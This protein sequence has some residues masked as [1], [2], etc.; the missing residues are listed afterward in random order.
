MKAKHQ[1][2]FVSELVVA[3]SYAKNGYEVYW[4]GFTQSSIDFIAVKNREM[5]RVQVKTA[6]WMTRHS[7][8]TYLQATVRKGCSGNDSYTIDD[9][10]VICITDGERIW[11]IPIEVASTLQ[12]VV[13]DKGQQIR[14]PDP[15]NFD[16]N[17]YLL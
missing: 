5:I 10:D 14:R 12:T 2:G 11:C 15:R 9:C 1:S 13:V 7:G 6:Y 16:A 4:P 3:T 17:P 8:A